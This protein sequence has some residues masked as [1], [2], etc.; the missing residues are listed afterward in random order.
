MFTHIGIKILH[1]FNHDVGVGLCL[2]AAGAVLWITYCL[3]W[4]AT[5]EKN[6]W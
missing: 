2:L 3:C 1:V 4:A 5:D 6:G